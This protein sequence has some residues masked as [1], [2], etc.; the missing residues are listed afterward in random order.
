MVGS[1]GVPPGTSPLIDEGAAE[2]RLWTVCVDYKGAVFRV[3]MI[4]LFT[5]FEVHINSTSVSTWSQKAP[6]RSIKECSSLCLWFFHL[7]LEMHQFCQ[8]SWLVLGSTYWCS[9]FSFYKL[10]TSLAFVKLTVV[11]WTY[12]ILISIGEKVHSGKCTLSFSILLE[13]WLLCCITLCCVNLYA[14]GEQI[15][16]NLYCYHVKLCVKITFLEAFDF[17]RPKTVR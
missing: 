3:Q 7:K 11:C 17:F 2:H 14:L 6:T 13:Y 12:W 16:Y 10:C 9:V 5:I 8:S 1:G 4:Q 15:S